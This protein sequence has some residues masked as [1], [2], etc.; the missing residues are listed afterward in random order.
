MTALD[1]E[2]E[3]FSTIRK[4]I[5]IPKECCRTSKRKLHTVCDMEKRINPSLFMLL[6]NEGVSVDQEIVK[7]RT[8]SE[9]EKLT[10]IEKDNYVENERKKTETIVK[11]GKKGA[12]TNEN[13]TKNVDE[14]KNFT[15][16]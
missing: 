14:Q 5:L 11:K 4:D 8:K 15:Q 2:L 13:P 10:N 9:R 6:L 3:D 16:K 12:E 7:R 1:Q